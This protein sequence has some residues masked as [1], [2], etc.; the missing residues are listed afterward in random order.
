VTPP[1]GERLAAQ[2]DAWQ[3]WRLVSDVNDLKWF[4]TWDELSTALPSYRLAVTGNQAPLVLERELELKPDQ[5]WLVIHASRGQPSDAP[6]RVT[7]SVEG[8][9]RSEFEVPLLDRDH[10]HALPQVIPL[11]D[12]APGQSIRLRIEQAADSA[13]T[14]ILWHSI[15][16][17]RFR[18]DIFEL[19]DESGSWISAADRSESISATELEDAFRGQRAVT[20]PSGSKFELS[21]QQPVAIRERPL[22]GEYRYIRFAFR[23]SVRGALDLRLLTPHGV[24]PTAYHAGPRRSDDRKTQRVWDRHLPAAW[25]VIT[26]DLARDVG[27]LDLIGL[28]VEFSDGHEL[29]LDNVYLARTLDDFTR[30]EQEQTAQQGREPE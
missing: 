12:L 5:R 2:L 21:W 16:L 26:R 10:L 23:A 20:F 7:V 22:L 14:P 17:T 29:S 30:W 1:L 15:S 13:R 11:T 9:L 24:H 19:F 6:P 27:D 28:Q 8:K 25:T 4:V 18:P 3:S